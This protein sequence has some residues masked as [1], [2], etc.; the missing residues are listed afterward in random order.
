MQGR[1]AGEGAAERCLGVVWPSAGYP[2][3]FPAWMGWGRDY[4]LLHYSLKQVC[5]IVVIYKFK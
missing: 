3:G 5:R 4:S 1:K 2:K